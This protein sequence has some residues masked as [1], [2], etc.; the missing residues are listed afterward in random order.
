M[1]L[2]LVRPS[3]IKVCALLRKRA[4]TV[5]F[6]AVQSYGDPNFNGHV[7]RR[8]PHTAASLRPCA[9]RSYK[10]PPPKRDVTSDGTLKF[11]RPHMM[12]QLALL[13]ALS[14]LAI[15]VVSAQDPVVFNTSSPLFGSSLTNCGTSGPVSCGQDGDPS[16][17]DLCCYESPGVSCIS[18]TLPVSWRYAQTDTRLRGCCYKHRYA[19]GSAVEFPSND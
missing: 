12:L 3:P 6:N 10:R 2:L 5:S 8:T 18:D 11:P 7:R 13:A 14:N 4:I 1:T 9:L 19:R 15:A 17:V 16:E